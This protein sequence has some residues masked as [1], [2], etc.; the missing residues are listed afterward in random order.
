MCVREGTM[1][2]P[3]PLKRTREPPSPDATPP[4][5]LTTQSTPTD[6]TQASET[7]ESVPLQPA[8]TR[9]KHTCESHRTIEAKKQK[10]ASNTADIRRFFPNRNTTT[11]PAQ[12]DTEQHPSKNNNR[13]VK[14]KLTDSSRL[15]HKYLVQQDSSQQPCIP[16]PYLDALLTNNNYPQSNHTHSSTDTANSQHRTPTHIP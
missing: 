9:K 5:T 3:Q 4:F 12:T 16:K 13:T 1:L 2:E 15:I 6:S 11:A 10:T 14:R 7:E 8:P